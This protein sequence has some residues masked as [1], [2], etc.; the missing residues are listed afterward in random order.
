M[1]GRAPGGVVPA[2][3]AVEEGKRGVYAVV[4][5][6]PALLPRELR[7]ARDLAQLRVDPRRPRVEQPRD[8]VALLVP[9]SAAGAREAVEAGA[10]ARAADVLR[11]L[12]RRDDSLPA[13]GPT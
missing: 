12:H 8:P 10:A 1:L 4:R 2:E 11:K 5:L 9:A 3:V 7:P 6:V 13:C